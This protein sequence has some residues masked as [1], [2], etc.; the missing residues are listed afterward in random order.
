MKCQGVGIHYNAGQEKSCSNG[1]R[2]SF[3]GDDDITIISSSSGLH[4]VYGTLHV[5]ASL[6]LLIFV[7]LISLQQI[8]LCLPTLKTKIFCCPERLLDDCGDGAT[9]GAKGD[10]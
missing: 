5:L 3:S 4:C 1:C 8:L 6:A 2:I 9:I 7:Y 10:R